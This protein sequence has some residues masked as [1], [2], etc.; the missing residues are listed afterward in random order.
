MVGFGDVRVTLDTQNLFFK[1]AYGVV[2]FIKLRIRPAL[3]IPKFNEVS[4][5]A[6]VVD[7]LEKKLP[8]G[9]RCENVVDF[10]SKIEGDISKIKDKVPFDFR[11]LLTS[12]NWT[13]D[14]CIGHGFILSLVLLLNWNL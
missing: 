1:G 6:D 2:N 5:N 3:D 9:E 8:F 12:Q 11:R 10:L 14:K 4:G 7:S 13:R